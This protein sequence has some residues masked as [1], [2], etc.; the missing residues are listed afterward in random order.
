M[1]IKI[2][3][4]LNIPAHKHTHVF[5]DSG[6]LPMTIKEFYLTQIDEKDFIDASDDFW[7]NK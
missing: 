4:L 1:V 3:K 6:I 7:F 2:S 5:T